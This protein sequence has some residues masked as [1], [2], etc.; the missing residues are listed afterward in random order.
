MSSLLQRVI[1]GGVFGAAVLLAMLF[2]PVSFGIL[3]ILVCVLCL[4]EYINLISSRSHSVV[5]WL[6]SFTGGL[7]LFLYITPDYPIRSVIMEIMIALFISF[8]IVDTVSKKKTNT[9]GAI[10]GFILVVFSL[11]CY[12]GLSHVGAHD[13]LILDGNS[14]EFS[15]I[16]AIFYVSLLWAN[17]SFAYFTGKF[18]GKTKLFERVSPNKTWEGFFGGLV[19]TIVVALIFNWLADDITHNISTTVVVAVLASVFGTMG[20]LFQSHTKRRYGVK[21][22]GNLL[23]GHGGFWDRFDGLLFAIPAIYLYLY[24]F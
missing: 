8:A 14:S 3:L 5:K 18:L 15:P 23:P 2:G 16:S 17:D 6:V 13:T 11:I 7:V 12:W 19:M 10:P 20:D 24:Y 9:I 1:T 22:S 21:D 4:Y